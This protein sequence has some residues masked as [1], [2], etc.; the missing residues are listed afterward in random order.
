M[1]KYKKIIIVALCFALLLSMF[2][3]SAF[4]YNIPDNGVFDTDGYYHID[5]GWT[6]AADSGEI[7]GNGIFII[8]VIPE[9]FNRIVFGKSSTGD[10]SSDSIV[11][12]YDSDVIYSLSS[13]QSCTFKFDFYNGE[14]SNIGLLGDFF[15]NYVQFA[16]FTVDDY[17]FRFSI[18]ENWTVNFIF[19]VGGQLSVES[20][21]QLYSLFV[22]LL[23][24][25]ASFFISADDFFISD[26]DLSFGSSE[27]FTIS[28]TISQDFF[29][30]EIDEFYYNLLLFFDFGFRNGIVETFEN[31]PTVLE[32]ILDIFLSV[33]SWISG[34][35]NSLIPMFWNAADG[36]LTF[37]GILSV[38]ALA[39]SVVFLV[40]SLIE[41]FLRFGG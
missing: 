34:A 40:L 10:S 37:V 36:T 13:D 6:V 28:G 26:P 14:S 24:N 5:D 1:K 23:D 15:E 33:G 8:D 12:Y 25:S 27:S 18:N 32:S 2:S 9:E 3:V 11:F 16:P 17:S 19:A 35:V 4:A 29:E 41:K 31:P 20:Q 22:C 30:G 39:L 21:S 38:S 7:I